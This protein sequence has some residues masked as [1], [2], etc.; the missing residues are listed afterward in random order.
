M[1][2]SSSGVVEA[3]I[4]VTPPCGWNPTVLLGQ[5][6]TLTFGAAIDAGSYPSGLSLAPLQGQQFTGT[7]SAKSLPAVQYTNPNSTPSSSNA[8]FAPFGLSF[9]GCG[10]MQNAAAAVGD[11][12]SYLVPFT[13][14]AQTAFTPLSS[15]T[16]YNIWGNL[17]EDACTLTVPGIPPIA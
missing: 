11:C 17:P 3:S 16:G 8:T 10:F 12:Y 5:K 9:C 14:D 6:A 1:V 4:R 15:S 7:L 2:T 13:P